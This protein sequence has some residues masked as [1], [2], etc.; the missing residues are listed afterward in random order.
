MRGRV[1]KNSKEGAFTFLHESKASF[2]SPLVGKGV[3]REL[4]IEFLDNLEILGD[5]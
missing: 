2:F 4:E 3:K 5:F 1:R